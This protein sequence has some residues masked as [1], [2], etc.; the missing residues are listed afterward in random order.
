MLTMNALLRHVGPVL[1]FV[2]LLPKN[3]LFRNQTLL[4]PHVV[5]STSASQRKGNPLRASQELE[6]LNK[7]TLMSSLFGKLGV[8]TYAN[9]RKGKEAL[10]RC[11]AQEKVGKEFKTQRMFK[12]TDLKK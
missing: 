5:Y 4:L 8:E 9:G 11:R 3:L 1:L 12:G 10:K 6:T 2:V 7:L